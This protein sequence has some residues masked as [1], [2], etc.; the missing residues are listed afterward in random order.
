MKLNRGISRPPVVGDLGAW[1]QKIF[2]SSPSSS[3]K[4]GETPFLKN[5]TMSFYNLKDN[6]VEEWGSVEPLTCDACGPC[7]NP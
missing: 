6:I 1:P 4:C 7:C 3:F 2:W 5:F